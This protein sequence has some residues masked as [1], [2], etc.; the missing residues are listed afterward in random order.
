[1]AKVPKGVTLPAFEDRAR[2]QAVL[3]RTTHYMVAT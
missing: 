3:P 1:M 2:P